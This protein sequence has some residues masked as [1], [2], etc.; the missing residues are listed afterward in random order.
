MCK[1]LQDILNTYKS[2]LGTTTWEYAMPWWYGTHLACP[3]LNNTDILD[4]IRYF[5]SLNV[6]MLDLFVKN[7]YLVLT[8]IK[9]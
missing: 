8:I 6:S 3:R 9:T 1:S 2:H 5:I 7:S 4:L